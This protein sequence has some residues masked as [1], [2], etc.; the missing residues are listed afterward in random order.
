MKELM[1]CLCYAVTDP[2]GGTDDIGSHAQVGMVTQVLHGVALCG[3]GIGLG[4]FD[5]ANDGDAV[6]S[7]FD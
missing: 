6:S 2:A 5:P 4:V 3:H 1:D 7:E